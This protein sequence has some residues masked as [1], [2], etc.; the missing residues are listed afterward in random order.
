MGEAEEEEEEEEEEDEYADFG[1]YGDYLA[2]EV[3][4]NVWT[5]LEMSGYE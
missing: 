4:V 3:R 5:K 1:E 2:I